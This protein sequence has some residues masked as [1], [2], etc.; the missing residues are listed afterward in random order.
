MTDFDETVGPGP[1]GD[2]VH[3]FERLLA[4]DV[5]DGPVVGIAL[6][7]SAA[8]ASL[9]ELLTWDEARTERIFS[10]A[11]I[12][13]EAAD[14]EIRSISGI[15]APNWPEW[16]LQRAPS[17]QERDVVAGAVSRLRGAAQ[18]PDAVVKSPALLRS[19]SDSV[20]LDSEEKRREFEV[21]KRRHDDHAIDDPERFSAWA[22][23]VRDVQANDHS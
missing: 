3:P 11:P 4:F 19:I 21:L 2:P 18:H 17:E 12:S 9:F 8:K 23:F 14:R 6:R 20:T 15:V 7:P 1:R 22:A 16:W 13:Y 5:Y 10:L